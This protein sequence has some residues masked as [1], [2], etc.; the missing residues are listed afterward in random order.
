MVGM[1]GYLV[2][3]RLETIRSPSARK[4]CMVSAISS[5]CV[6]EGSLIVLSSGGS[7]WVGVLS[8]ARS[9]A[10]FV[11]ARVTADSVSLVSLQPTDLTRAEG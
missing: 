7:V 1:N 2:G 9:L 5:I 3:K 6:R 8:V 4:S 10:K 11:C